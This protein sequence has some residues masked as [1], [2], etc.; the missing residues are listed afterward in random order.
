MQQTQRNDKHKQK[1]MR[2]FI[3]FA[4]L[5]ILATAALAQDYKGWT[6][7]TRD[8]C[9]RE[10]QDLC[11]KSQTNYNSKVSIRISKFN[12]VKSIEIKLA[13]A[14][15]VVKSVK[16]ELQFAQLAL[17]KAKAEEK[18]ADKYTTWVCKNKM[19][20]R[21]Y[22]DFLQATSKGG[23]RDAPVMKSSMLHH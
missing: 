18:T 14:R 5:A 9:E 17:V 20:T 13:Q 22:R 19:H 16:T 1:H 23:K 2:A 12:I 21:K 15:A 3:I 6:R 11:R 10:K 8:A 7:S 4:V